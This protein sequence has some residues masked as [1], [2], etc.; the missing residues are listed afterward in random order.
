MFNIGD[1]IIYSKHGLSQIADICEKTI[2]NETRTYYV[3]HPLAESNLTIS[4]PV[5]SDK[6]VMLRML[7]REEGEEILQSFHEPGIYWIDDI[8]Q[9]SRRY[10][11]IVKTGDRKKIAGV[12][13]TLMR[14]EFEYSLKNKKLYDQDRRLLISVQNILFKEIAQCLKTSFEEVMDHVHNIIKE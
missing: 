1:V 7:T 4:A 6:V 14:K 11:E 12:A 9:R 5:D 13:N 2:L 3:L 8:R 10:N